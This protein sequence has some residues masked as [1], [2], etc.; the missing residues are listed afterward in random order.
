MTELA[1][2]PGNAI[3]RTV[4][5]PAAQAARGADPRAAIVPV[6]QTQDPALVAAWRALATRASEPNPFFEPWFL[7]PSLRHLAEPDEC[8]LLTV[9]EGDALIGLMPIAQRGDY[10]GYRIAHIASWLHDNAF[11]G[12]PLVAKHGEQAFWQCVLDHCDRHAGTALFLHLAELPADGPVARALDA[13][14][15]ERS[16]AAVTVDRGERAMLASPASPDAYWQGAM[17]AKNR[18]ELRR[19]KK[20][21]GECG[22]LSFERCEDATDPAEWAREFVALEAAGWKGEARSALASRTATCDFFTETLEGAA[23]AGRLERLALRLDGKPVAMLANFLTPPGAYSF[24]TAYDEAYAR[25]SPG[26]LLQIENLDLLERD[27]IAWTDSCARPGHT[28]IERLWREKRVIEARNIAIGGRVRRAL[29][30]GLS[31][32]ENRKGRRA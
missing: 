23:K 18:K 14:T 15:R 5:T 32:W 26:L 3:F 4:G 11:C 31:A 21:L 2:K 9:W 7:L 28:M 25:Y 20:R 12:V 24:K 13:V 27:G 29:F 19:Q 30:A 10:Y 22:T 6:T 1:R 16:C 17:S 8:A